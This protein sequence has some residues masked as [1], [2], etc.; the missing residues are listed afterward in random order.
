M[1]KQY[2]LAFF[3]VAKE[4]NT[5]DDVKESFDV[6]VKILKS[7][8]D[9]ERVLISP[10]IK[11]DEKKDLIKKTFCN[12]SEDFIFFLFI[13]LDNGRMDKIFNIYEEFIYLY[14]EENNIK[15]VDIL[16]AELLS[17]AEKMKLLNSLKKH[18][19]NYEVVIRNKIDPKVIGGY[20][21]LVNGLSLDLSIKRKIDDLEKHI[22]TN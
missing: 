18:Y 19:S 6:F 16:S 15:L 14:N 13:V 17:D 4:D 22:L 9:F 2:A 7:E 20:H 11:I 8:N 10:K 1:N 3:E 21:I 5:L 12:C